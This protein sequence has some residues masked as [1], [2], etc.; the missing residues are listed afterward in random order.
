MALC[1][2]RSYRSQG[3]KERRGWIAVSQLH[4]GGY[5]LF[6]WDT[7]SGHVADLG[8]QRGESKACFALGP[9]R[10]AAL[11]CSIRRGVQIGLILWGS[12]WLW[13]G[14]VLLAQPAPQASVWTRGDCV[15]APSYSD[16]FGPGDSGKSEDPQPTDSIGPEDSEISLLPPVEDGLRPEP[17]ERGD[18]L[19]LENGPACLA[20]EPFCLSEGPLSTERAFSEPPASWG[21][22]ELPPPDLTEEEL[23]PFRWLRYRRQVHAR[24]R[25]FWQNIQQDHFHFYSWPTVRDVG[26]GLALGAVLA[27]TSLDP[28]FQDWYQEDVRSGGLDNLSSFWKPWGEG[29]F[30]IPS[31]AG[32]AMLSIFCP[33]QPVL[34]PVGLFSARVSR[35]YLVG[36]PS[37]L[38]L[39]AMTGG[40]RPGE[41]PTMSQWR[42]FEDTNGISGHAF[43]GAVPF[44]TAAQMTDRPL[45]QAAFY[46][47]SVFP[48]WSR[49]NDD[50]HYLSQVCLGWWLAYLAC[51]AVNETETGQRPWTLVPIAGGNQIGLGLVFT[52]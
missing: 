5:P 28:H 38:F 26:L 9:I 3:I 34:G 31:Y 49:M 30:F 11:S 1:E 36:F 41:H 16:R 23:E 17:A 40:G 44:I 14:A 2:K 33:E 27:N 52:R 48:A 39:Q 19:F 43:I 12:L 21:W 37:V 29:I 4:P 22:S 20:E 50:V 13:P 32:L 35:A 47:G 24:V 8:S 45:L 51:R 10:E 42:P 6:P 7:V 18:F 25:L 15:L 46:L